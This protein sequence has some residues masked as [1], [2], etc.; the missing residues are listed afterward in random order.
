MVT[1]KFGK[2][3]AAATYP[4]STPVPGWNITTWKDIHVTESRKLHWQKEPLELYFYYMSFTPLGVNFST[5]LPEH[6]SL[7]KEF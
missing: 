6:F 3:C 4:C 2:L 5:A 7:L 1:L